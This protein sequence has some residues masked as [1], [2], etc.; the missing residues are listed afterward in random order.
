MKLL[1]TQPKQIK[2]NPV[3][4]IKDE[5][6]KNKRMVY[7]RYFIINIFSCEYHYGLGK[8]ALREYQT[9][10]KLQIEKAVGGVKQANQ[11]PVYNF[12]VNTH[13]FP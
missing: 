11:S 13:S 6:K 8:W 9:V 2:A 3:Y 4:T 10:M 1:H 5:R 7:T 12:I